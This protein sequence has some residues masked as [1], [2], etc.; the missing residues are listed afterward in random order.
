M[1]HIEAHKL[2]SLSYE[3]RLV[4]E[5]YE[6]PLLTLDKMNSKCWIIGC[7]ID[8]GLVLWIESRGACGYSRTK[9]ESI[10]A[11]VA[12][13]DPIRED[14]AAFHMLLSHASVASSGTQPPVCKIHSYPM[15]KKS[16]HWNTSCK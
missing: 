6:V 16:N 5:L 9:F 11:A 13:M 14:L 2:D 1:S 8:P 15:Y 3:L 7:Y 10:K 12:W 4:N